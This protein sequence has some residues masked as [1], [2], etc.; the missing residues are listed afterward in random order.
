MIQDAAEKMREWN[1]NECGKAKAEF[2]S[3]VVAAPESSQG[4]GLARPT[5]T[6]WAL[7]CFQL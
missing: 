5:A 3:R 7:D 6:A 1:K 4:S 2:H